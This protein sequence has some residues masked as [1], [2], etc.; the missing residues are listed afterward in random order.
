MSWVFSLHNT[1]SKGIQLGPTWCW[2][3]V[4]PRGG[5]GTDAAMEGLF[6]PT[7]CCC[8]GE[9]P[10]VW[11]GSDETERWNLA[12]VDTKKSSPMDSVSMH[13]KRVQR[14]RFSLQRNRVQWTRFLCK[15]TES[16]GLGFCAIGLVF[17]VRFLLESHSA[18]IEIEPYLLELL[19]TKIV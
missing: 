9:Q 12:V 7:W 5:L 19:K 17:C 16:F 18:T 6:M 1:S 10:A 14:T 15:E 13:R 2:G 4:M 3:T 11:D 8:C